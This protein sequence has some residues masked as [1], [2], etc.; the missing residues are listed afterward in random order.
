[1]FGES[2]QVVTFIS[3]SKSPSF[4]V[5][6]LNG[7]IKDYELEETNEAIS[8]R[9]LAHMGIQSIVENKIRKATA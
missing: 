2:P 6:K 4:L 5:S 1:L 8:L 3:L 7:E 9:N